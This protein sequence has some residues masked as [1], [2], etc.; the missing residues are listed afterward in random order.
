MLLD[1]TS[2]CTYVATYMYNYRMKTTLLL[3]SLQ[4][5]F[6]EKACEEVDYEVENSSPHSEE[7]EGEGMEARE[8][9]GEVEGEEEE[10][11][12]EAMEMRRQQQKAAAE[13]E[14][15]C[16]IHTCVAQVIGSTHLV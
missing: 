16:T 11:R 12:E 2:E 14:K 13:K 10:D 1:T 6:Q 9:E 3:S 8:G 5:V 7:E 4:T 15:V